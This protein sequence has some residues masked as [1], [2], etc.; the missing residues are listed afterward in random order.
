MLNAPEGDAVSPSDGATGAG[1]VGEYTGFEKLNAF[2]V[3][4][5]INIKNFGKIFTSGEY[6]DILRKIE[7]ASI[8]YP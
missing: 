5:V 6:Y 7:S 3:S 8:Y 4:T 2:S 1:A